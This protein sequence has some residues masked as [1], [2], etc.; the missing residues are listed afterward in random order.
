VATWRGA[1]P[2]LIKVNAYVNSVG[3]IKA[4]AI[5]RARTQSSARFRASH[6]L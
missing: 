5:Q 3:L 6:L 2:A 4:H 1:L